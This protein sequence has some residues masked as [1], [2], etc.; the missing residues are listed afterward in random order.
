MPTCSLKSHLIGPCLRLVGNA[1]KHFALMAFN[2]PV[3]SST[4]EVS[5]R[6]GLLRLACRGHCIRRSLQ[7]A[8]SNLRRLSFD[9]TQRRPKLVPKRYYCCFYRG[10]IPIFTC[11]LDSRVPSSHGLIG[12]VRGL[13]G[14]FTSFQ[15]RLLRTQSFRFCATV[16]GHS[17]ILIVVG[18]PIV[19]KR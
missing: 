17:S 8:R 11:Y 5:D 4:I 7:R 12:T 14:H 10:V 19:D 18:H 9:R 15:T 1:G 13:D 3:P 6:T 16:V 2:P